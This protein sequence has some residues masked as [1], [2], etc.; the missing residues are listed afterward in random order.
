MAVANSQMGY[1]YNLPGEKRSLGVFS[2]NYW[3]ILT[4]I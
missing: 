4:A 2:G 3:A 1:R